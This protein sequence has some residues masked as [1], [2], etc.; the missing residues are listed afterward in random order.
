M[1]VGDAFLFN[2]T[3]SDDG[4]IYF[5]A[6]TDGDPVSKIVILNFTT[7]RP[8]KCDETCVIKPHE[9]KVLSHTSV[10]AYRFGRVEV[11]N[12]Q[13]ILKSQIGKRLDPIPAVVM[14]RIHAGAL[15]S[16]FTPIKIKDLLRP[17]KYS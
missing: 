7:Y 15:T 4:H 6:Y 3:V 11:E 1:T 12:V 16:K 14:T 9:Y 8:G 10:V 13:T 17:T 5:I 2:P